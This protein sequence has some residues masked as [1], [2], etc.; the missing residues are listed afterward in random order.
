MNILLGKK[1]SDPKQEE[2]SP[3]RLAVTAV[4]KTI[5]LA[6]NFISLFIL[7]RFRIVSSVYFLDNKNTFENI[8]MYKLSCFKQKGFV[9]KENISRS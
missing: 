6:E 8:Q 7:E 4:C 3:A 5:H 9:Y 2:K 1:K